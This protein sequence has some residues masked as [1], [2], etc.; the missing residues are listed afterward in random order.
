MQYWWV[1]QG[2]TLEYELMGGYLWSPKTKKNGAKNKFYDNMLLV[3]SGDVIFSFYKQNIVAVGQAT[4]KAATSEKPNF[5]ELDEHWTSSGWRVPVRFTRLRRQCCPKNFINELRPHM[6]ERY[7]PLD[8][9][10]G[11]LQGVYLTAVS[12]E[13]AKVLLGKMGSEAPGFATPEQ[14]T[15]A[16]GGADTE[17]AISSPSSST[18]PIVVPNEVSEIIVPIV[19]TTQ[20]PESPPYDVKEVDQAGSSNVG[21]NTKI[22]KERAEPPKNG[23]W[24]YV[25]VGI[26]ICIILALLAVGHR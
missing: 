7:A 12:K 17:A 14:K 11:G 10:G 4:G 3:R 15:V 13:F 1:N 23:Q 9:A 19:A 16:S 26:A 22:M 2:K 5:G 18:E 8:R 20:M 21:G 6:A 25:A 24:V